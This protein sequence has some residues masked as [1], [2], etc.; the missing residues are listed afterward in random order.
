ME[1]DGQVLVGHVDQLLSGDFF[2]AQGVNT[3][4]RD[5][6]ATAEEDP[7]TTPLVNSELPTSGVEPEDHSGD[8][9]QSLI[10]AE[11]TEDG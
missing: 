5:S 10:I 11:S 9:G 7:T 1:T 8:P 6:V 4:S 3:P 2:S